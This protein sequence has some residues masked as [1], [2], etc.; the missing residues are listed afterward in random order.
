MKK[1]W[2]TPS[3]QLMKDMGWMSIHREIGYTRMILLWK[4]LQVNKPRK[5][6]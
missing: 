6:V 4:M 3:E 5:L 2:R 1:N